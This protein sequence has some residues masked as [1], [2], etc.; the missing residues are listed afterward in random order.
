MMPRMKEGF[1]AGLAFTIPTLALGASFGVL[2]EPVIG[3]TAAIVMSL[4][5]FAGAAQFASVSVL[6]AGGGVASAVSTGLLINTRFLPMGLALA[7]ALRGGRLRRA[8]EAQAMVDASWALANRG[9]GKFD[10]GLM[11]GATIPQAACWW[12]GT[13]IGALGGSL[14]GD[15]RALGLDAMFPAFYLALLLTEMDLK[16]TGLSAL[17]GAAIALCLVPFA[18]PGIPI[19][20]ASA[21]ALLGLRER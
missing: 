13:A 12:A 10:R 16:R 5:V 19:V 18:P 7:P 6:A 21:A 9:D 3:A 11:L 1:K 14:I 4:V 17:L 8:A 15:P 20:A 2:A